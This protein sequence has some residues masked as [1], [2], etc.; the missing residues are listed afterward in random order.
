[1][2]TSEKRKLVAVLFSDIKGYTAM[3]QENEDIA[4]A[5]VNRHREVLEAH[6]DGNGGRIVTFYGD[7]A[8]VI[9]ESAVAA[10]SSAVQ[11]QRDFIRHGVPV[12]IGLHLGDV[13]FKNDSVFGDGVNIAS[14]IQAEGYPG[15]VLISES[16][17]NKK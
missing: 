16:K 11:M 2:T 14:R 3:V 15:A 17:Q 1:M 10:V 13:A 6:T 8:L 9:F 12:R 7:G 5:H 4:L